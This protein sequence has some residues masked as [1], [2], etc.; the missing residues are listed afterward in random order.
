[1]SLLHFLPS[2]FVFF[3]LINCYN[4][5]NMFFPEFTTSTT[6]EGTRLSYSDFRRRPKASIV[7]F[8]PTPTPTAWFLWSSPLIT[9]HDHDRKTKKFRKAVLYTFDTRTEVEC[10]KVK[11]ATL[12]SIVDSIASS[13]QHPR[14]LI[15]EQAYRVLSSQRK[16]NGRP[17]SSSQPATA[18]PSRPTAATIITTSAAVA[19]AGGRAAAPPPLLLATTETTT[20]TRRTTKVNFSWLMMI[21]YS[22]YSL[23]YFL[24][25]LTTSLLSTS[26]SSSPTFV[27]AAASSGH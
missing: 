12:N 13:S 4:D 7:S 24:V 14:G 1:M 18:T 26:S 8:S 10:N 19:A 15:L 5:L 17:P 11:L 27:L 3:F 22:I 16:H 2:F 25:Q 9:G 23:Y 20:T 21:V 6:P